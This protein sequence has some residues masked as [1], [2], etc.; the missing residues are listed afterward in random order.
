[1]KNGL[2]NIWL[3]VHIPVSRNILSIS[4]LTNP[5]TAGPNYILF[6]IFYQQLLNILK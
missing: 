1:M 4:M 2:K 6:F 5:L 3:V